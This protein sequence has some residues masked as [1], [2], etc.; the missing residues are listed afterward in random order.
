MPFT[1]SHPAAVLPLKQ[2]FPRYFSLTGLMAGAMAPDLLYFL[3]LD[4]RHRGVSHS[5]VGLFTFCLPAGILFS[6][7]F[8]WLF[9]YHVIMN[10]PQPLDRFFSGLALK[11]FKIKS[12]RQWLILA[13]SILIGAISHFFWD[14]FTHTQGELARMLPF[15]IREITILGITRP[16][17]T[18]LQ[19]LST[20]SGGALV[21]I[22]ALKSNLMPGPAIEKSINDKKRKLLFWIISVCFA[23]IFAICAMMLRDYSQ[24]GHDK[25]LLLANLFKTFGLASWAGFFYFVCAYTLFLPAGEADFRHMGEKSR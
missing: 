5:W 23:A 16:I 21:L 3:L 11:R 2:F 22:Y 10:L 4:T 8:H 18:F 24:Y 7:A 15:L 25:F 1:T 19:H 20:I 13:V 12:P 6:F 17:C 9:K 14:S